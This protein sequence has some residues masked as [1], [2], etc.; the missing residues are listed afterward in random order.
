MDDLTG[1]DWSSSSNSTTNNPP[2]TGN[3][4]PS[5]RPTPPPQIPGRHA[6]LSTQASEAPNPSTPP[7]SSTPDSFS[8]L[9]SFGSSKTTRLTLQEQQENLQAQ[10]RKRE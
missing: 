3:Y 5:L 7:K 10:Q 9:V 8:N 4:Y 6:P 1:L 2:A